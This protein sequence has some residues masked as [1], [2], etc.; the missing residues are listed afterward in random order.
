[1]HQQLSTNK[2]KLKYC[3]IELYKPKLLKINVDQI[4]VYSKMKDVKLLQYLG[5]P[6]SIYHQKFICFKT[7]GKTYKSNIK[8]NDLELIESCIHI[9]NTE[10]ERAETNLNSF[11]I[12]VRTFLPQCS[13][14]Y[15]VSDGSAIMVVSYNH[16]TKRWNEI[17][18]E[19]K[20]SLIPFWD[21]NMVREWAYLPN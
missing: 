17:D 21:H 20:D 10:E 14:D 1:M 7:N 12:D 2:E 13:G 6:P 19:G 9:L 15:L 18:C 3:L 5:F 4:I 8:K 16:I 11:W